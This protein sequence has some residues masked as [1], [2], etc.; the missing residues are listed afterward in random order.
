MSTGQNKIAKKTPAKRGTRGV[1]ACDYCKKLKAK[2]VPS[3][4]P[5]EVRCLR[6]DSLKRHCS[7][8]DL[9]TDSPVHAPAHDG[10]STQFNNNG[11]SSDN[12]TAHAELLKAFLKSGSASP[13]VLNINLKYT[14]MI[15]DN[16]LKVLALL[17]NSVDA[18]SERVTETEQT[19]LEK[20]AMTLMKEKEPGISSSLVDAVSMITRDGPAR[21]AIQDVSSG[22]PEVSPSMARNF[23]DQNHAYLSSSYTLMSQLV[24]RDHLPLLIRKLH[25]HKFNELERYLT[26]DIVTMNIITLEESYMLMQSFRNRYSDWCSFPKSIPNEKLVDNI[27]SK[28]SSFLLTVVCTLALRYTDDYHDLKTRCYKNLLLKLRSDV[29]VS[30]SYVP[31]SKEFLQAIVILSLYASSFSSDFLCVDAWYLS[32]V[33]SQHLITRGVAGSLVKKNKNSVNTLASTINLLDPVMQPDLDTFNNSVFEETEEFE[34]LSS[35]RLWN[36]L[37]HCHINNCVASGRM[38][39]IDDR[40]LEM[41]K[42]TLELP[43]S[44]N[45]DGRMVAEIELTRIVYKF[46]RSLEFFD[47]SDQ[48]PLNT[49]LSKLKGWLEQWNYLFTQPVTQF[50]EFNY[51]YSICLVH[52]SWYH[53]HYVTTHPPDNLPLFNS[54]TNST[55]TAIAD[56]LNLT[57]PLKKVVASILPAQVSFILEHAHLGLTAI[58]NCPFEKFKFLSDH[59]VFSGVHLALMCLL[60]LDESHSLSKDI[61]AVAILTDVKKLSQ[62]LQKIREGELKSFWVEEVDLRIPSVI[63]QYHKALEAYLIGKFSAYDIQI[64]PNYS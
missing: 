52:Y 3:P 42:L 19:P 33:G 31:Q 43:H 46:I 23:D 4:V 41:C 1:K 13:S 8:E 45:F 20:E 36:H 34:Q 6:C 12:E 9:F 47:I 32:A 63:L 30:L 59:L 44:T 50:V 35:A 14:K 28:N 11:S 24:P 37:C 18:G 16:V 60:L 38:C 57:Y 22:K 62:R 26:E 40:S 48:Q 15:H 64:D 56:Y 10:T 17:E 7:F 29:E 39:T 55:K 54:A 53:K 27:R 61:D 21:A 25:D 51:H 5:G 58:V 2:C 49:V